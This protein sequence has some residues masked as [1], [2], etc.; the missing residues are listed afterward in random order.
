MRMTAPALRRALR[1]ALPL[2]GQHFFVLYGDSYLDIAYAP[3]QAAYRDSGLPAL[4]TVFRNEGKWDTSNVLFDGKRVVRYDKRHPTPDMKFIDYGLGLLNGDL[5]HTAKDEVFD[6]SD[7][8]GTLAREGRLAGFEE[9][10]RFYEI[11]TPSGL[12][13]TDGHLRGNLQT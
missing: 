13:E 6:L 5:L 9:T 4:M 12:A 7:L 1:R 3:V 2:L 8:Y 10:Q 11:G